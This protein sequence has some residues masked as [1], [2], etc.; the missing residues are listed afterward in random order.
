MSD[1]KSRLEKAGKARADLVSHEN[2]RISPEFC[3]YRNGFIKGH[4]DL[5][6]WVVRLTNI[7]DRLVSACEIE[8][9]FRKEGPHP[10]VRVGRDVL[11]SL[12]AYLE[13]EK[14]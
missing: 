9:D 11:R 13:G 7:L 10:D 8:A 12:E 14:K 5:A 3:L 2:T 1:L 6:D 4:A